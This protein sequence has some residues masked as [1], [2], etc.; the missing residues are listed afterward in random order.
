MNNY[1]VFGDVAGNFLTLKALLAKMPQDAEPLCLGDPVDRGP[2]SKEVVE[3]LMT[4]GKTVNSN[5]AHLMIE[6]W[7]QS[8][9]PGAHNRY[10]EKGVWFF[11]GAEQ[12]M[13]SYD[14]DWKKKINYDDS[15]IRMDIVKYEEFILHTLIP[16][17]HI[18]FLERCPLYIESEN[19]VMTH[20]PLHIQLDL[21]EA[22]NIGNG[23]ATPNLGHDYNSHY[24]LLW[25]RYVGDHPN[26]T[27]NGK[28]N[29][30]G[31]NSSDSAKVYTTQYPQG[32]KVDNE[33][34][35]YLLM[36]KDT[37]PIFNICLDT[38][39]GK[40]LTGLHLPTMILYEQKYID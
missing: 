25:N 38:S 40:K 31:H 1:N 19:F 33:K 21:K 39:S 10:Y 24:S 30:F 18:E 5:H 4:N 13:N 37:Y 35:Q 6:D 23:F 27:L 14:L 26:P 15:Q 22:S 29:I 36:L 8:A 3:F 12:T 2:R 9:M 11:N 34:L 28:I 7:K 17:D 16:R 20:A 32:I